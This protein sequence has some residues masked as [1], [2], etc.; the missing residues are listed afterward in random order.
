MEHIH[1]SKNG[2]N[3][4]DLSNVPLKKW[5]DKMIYDWQSIKDW[6][7]V[8]FE[9]G[10]LRDV[11]LIYYKKR[12]N[13]SHYVTMNYGACLK[14][15]YCS[16]LLSVTF[17]GLLNLI[18]IKNES[19]FIYFEDGFWEAKHHTSGE[20]KTVTL[21][22][23]NCGSYKQTRMR[24]I[25]AN[26]FSCDKCSSNVTYPERFT[27]ALLDEMGFE[28][29]TQKMFRDKRWRFDFYI[30]RLKLVIE[31]HGAQHFN[32]AWSTREE[33]STNDNAKR[34]FIMFDLGLN[35]S[36]IDISVSEPYYAWSMFQDS[37]LKS[38]MGNV[39]YNKVIKRCN[40]MYT[41]HEY[42]D[43]INMY[44][45]GSLPYEVAAQFN[46][47]TGKVINL[48]KRAGVYRDY[49][50]YYSGISII[51]ITTGEIFNSA[52]EVEKITNINNSN[53][54]K[55]CKNKQSFAGRTVDGRKRVWMYLEDYEKK[56]GKFDELLTG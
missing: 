4:I 41:I 32:N 35:Y 2:K 17:G 10:D 1:Y 53:V 26:G 49:N 38:Y 28:Y 25:S 45:E 39:E 27:R 48:L 5:G 40:E 54:I 43:I 11:M 20:D 16:D 8:E 14:D 52:L 6:I 18:P 9:Y 24:N 7:E 23:P 30:P 15:V 44:L 12:D 46:V 55:V 37:L 56:Y 51:C 22:C 13:G 47:T 36:A 3:W 19:L 50:L 31:V 29:E 42:E 34:K 33:T 21:K